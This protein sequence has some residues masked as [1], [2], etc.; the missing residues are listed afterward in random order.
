VKNFVLSTA[1]QS[2]FGDFE[3]GTPELEERCS[4]SLAERIF[5]GQIYRVTQP[6]RGHPSKLSADQQ[7]VS[8][9]ERSASV[10]DQ[11]AAVK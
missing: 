3:K 8:M 9:S 1:F 5:D 4:K 11:T 2:F 6:P 7:R 10:G